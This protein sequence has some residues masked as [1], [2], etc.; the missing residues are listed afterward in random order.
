M[1]EEASFTVSLEEKVSGAAG[2][3]TG[4][5]ATL[6]AQI[7]RES[8]ALSLMEAEMKRVQKSGDIAAYD[9]LSGAIDGQKSKL[10]GLT[11]QYIDLGN[12]AGAPAEKMSALSSVSDGLSSKLDAM[13]GPLKIAAALFAA[14]V[15]A[16][17]AAGVALVKFALGQ[18]DAERQS[19]LTMEAILGS[20][21]AASELDEVIDKMA[22]SSSVSSER[23][24]EFATSLAKAG[25]RGDDLVQSLDLLRKVEAG[26]GGEAASKLQGII[27]KAGAAG[28]F[29]VSAKQLSE[30]GINM[31][32]LAAALGV[33]VADIE[34]KMNSGAI[35]VKEGVAAL[36]KAAAKLGDVDA[37][38]ALGFGKQMDKLKENLGQLFTDIN[39]EPFLEGL[40]TV[41]DLFSQN[42]ESGRAMKAIFT[43]VFDGFFSIASKVFPYVKAAV[44]GLVLIALKLYIA[45]KPV[46]A[47]ISEAFGGDSTS[48]I[49]TF[50]GYLRNMAAIV[51]FVAS[52]IGSTLAGAIYVVTGAVN[53]ASIVFGGLVAAFD[54]VV[55]AI[56]SIDLGSVGSAMIEGLVVGILGGVGGVVAAMGSIG[57]AAKSAL[58]SAL[59]IRSPSKVFAGLGGFTAEG[60]AQGVEAGTP[61][62]ASAVTDM[63]QTPTP[64][65]A[66]KGAAAGGAAG[67]KGGGGGASIQ[68]GN[69]TIPL[70]GVKDAA[71][72]TEQLPG[73]LADAF[74]RLGLQMGAAT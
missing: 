6:E 39:I 21:E 19:L 40:K 15:V 63:V 54:A 1:A 56:S 70:P 44:L 11:N 8:S 33:S 45:F 14:L 32:D 69:I 41:T 62:V 38:K 43:K 48:G 13:G 35:S 64:S 42:T 25:L 30:V 31:A 2:K 60:F 23:L 24:E 34:K 53:G 22:A 37:K 17:V 3:A 9:K 51:G 20:A 16:V 47:A 65:A 12:A 4:A 71:S 73:A 5:L 52:V 18:A 66:V 57:S 49:E 59:K 58:E 27:A 28:K 50:T 10:S 68:I 61:A 7:K 29:D 36:N 46:G 26:V 74:E 67:G 55:G 72:F